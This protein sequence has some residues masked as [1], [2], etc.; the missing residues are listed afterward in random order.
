[1]GSCCVAAAEGVPK[2]TQPHSTRG[3]CFAAGAQDYVFSTSLFDV[4]MLSVLRTLV[5][6]VA[7][8]ALGERQNCHK[9]YL[10]AT[11]LSL[12]ATLAFTFAK[13]RCLAQYYTA[14]CVA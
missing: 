11:H 6:M 4:V 14:R 3:G 12:L 10:W 13:V 9:P 5:L 8:L 2:H 7:Y 1:M